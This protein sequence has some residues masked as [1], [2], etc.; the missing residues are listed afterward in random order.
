LRGQEKGT[1]EKAAPM[2]W[3]LAMPRTFLPT[4]KK[5]GASQLDLAGPRFLACGRQRIGVFETLGG[6]A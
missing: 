1:K 3:F 5:R 2:R 4:A 6:Y